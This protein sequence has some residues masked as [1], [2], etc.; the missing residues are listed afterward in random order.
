MHSYFA[1]LSSADTREVVDLRTDEIG[2]EWIALSWESPCNVTNVSVIYSIERCDGEN[3]NQTN[4]TV[5]WHNAT[6]LEPCT[7]YAF[8]VKTLTESWESDGVPLSATTDHASECSI[9]L[10][11]VMSDFIE[12][13][14]PSK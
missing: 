9:D 10:S 11:S 14:G 8:K 5:T 13:E 3:C 4:E 1:I 2:T 6:D 7:Q 12:T